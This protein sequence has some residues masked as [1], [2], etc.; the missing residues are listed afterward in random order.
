MSKRSSKDEL[1]LL[2]QTTEATLAA[3]TLQISAFVHNGTLD[4]RCAA[5]LIKRLR[6][7]ADLVFDG[8]NS[9][10]EGRHELAKALDAVDASLREHDAGL[11]VAA[12]AALRVTEETPRD[13]A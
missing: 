2:N 6:Q 9:T 8:G 1:E 5:K 13:K 11:L 7:E 10:E 12:H 4:S 3:L